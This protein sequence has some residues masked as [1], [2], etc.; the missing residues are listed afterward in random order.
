MSSALFAISYQEISLPEGRLPR[1]TCFWHEFPDHLA[2]HYP[3]F[4]FPTLVTFSHTPSCRLLDL[5]H[6]YTATTTPLQL[7]RRGRRRPFVHE[8]AFSRFFHALFAVDTLPNEILAS[9]GF[10][11]MQDLSGAIS[12]ICHAPY[13]F[14]GS[15]IAHFSLLVFH[16]ARPEIKRFILAISQRDD[17]ERLR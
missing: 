13:I 9:A 11:Y 4:R 6:I 8:I 16:H 5:M 17:D 7:T 15:P 3:R 12:I 1:V 10:H 14:F 2:P